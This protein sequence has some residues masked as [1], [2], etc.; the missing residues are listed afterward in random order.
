MPDIT[1]VS[2]LDLFTAAPK[3]QKPTSNSSVITFAPCQ[4][5][6]ERYLSDRLVAKRYA[7][8]RATIWRWVATMPKF[9]KPVKVSPGASRWKISE[10]VNFEAHLS[11]KNSASRDDKTSDGC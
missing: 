4:L 3:A 5:C 9:P 1:D 7:V 2:Q 10:L 8:S 11:T 6:K